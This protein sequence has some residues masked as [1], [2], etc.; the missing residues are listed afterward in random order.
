[1]R[2]AGQ[3]GGAGARTGKATQGKGTAK[4]TRKKGIARG[5]KKDGRC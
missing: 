4:Q 3:Y 5:R 2:D 1:M